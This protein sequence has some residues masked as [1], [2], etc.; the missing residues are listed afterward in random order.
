LKEPTLY[1]SVERRWNVTDVS[2]YT[3]RHFM[4]PSK[5]GFVTN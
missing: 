3:W 5:T 4:A 1:N 2:W